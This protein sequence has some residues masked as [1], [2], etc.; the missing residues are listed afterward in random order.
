MEGGRR[1]QDEEPT[2]RSSESDHGRRDEEN[3]SYPAG[4]LSNPKQEL[5]QHQLLALL[6]LRGAQSGE[7]D[8]ADDHD[9]PFSGRRVQF[10]RLEGAQLYRMG[11]ERT[12]RSDDQGVSAADQVYLPPIRFVRR[13]AATRC[14]VHS[15]K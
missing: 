15:A 12:I 11:L 6:L 5:A 10:V 9:E 4:R 1:R 3:E 13:R 14:N 7:R 2:A 8:P